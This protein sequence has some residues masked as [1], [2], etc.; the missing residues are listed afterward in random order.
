M[1]DELFNNIFGDFFENIK[2]RTPE[3]IEKEK[4][5]EEKRRIQA[6]K[7]K[8]QFLKYARQL[9]GAEKERK[10]NPII[11]IRGEVI[12]GVEKIRAVTADELFED[13]FSDIFSDMESQSQANTPKQYRK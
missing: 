7:E 9:P 4:Q 13:L 10:D 11:Q 12:D 3:E 8:E 5:E 1:N 6:K 2:L